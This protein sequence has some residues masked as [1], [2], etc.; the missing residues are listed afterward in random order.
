VKV[1]YCNFV[2]L[3]FDKWAEIN[4]FLT[5]VVLL[6]LKLC[7][8]EKV[9]WDLFS[10]VIQYIFDW[11]LFIGSNKYEFEIIKASFHIYYIR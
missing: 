4:P 1:A 5:R 10:R 6:V 7:R 11:V 9:P 3:I 2:S 8:N